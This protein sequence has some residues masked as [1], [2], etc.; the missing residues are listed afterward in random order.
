MHKSIK[1]ILF[2][3]DT[4]HVSDGLPVQYQELET[5]HT[6]TGICQTNNSDCLLAGTSCLS[7]SCAGKMVD[8][9]QR[10]QNNC[11]GV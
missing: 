5:I 4:L 9:Y 1:Y 11:Y 7:T 8:H 3:N 6:A 2:L 10:T